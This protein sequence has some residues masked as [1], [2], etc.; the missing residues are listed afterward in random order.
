MDGGNVTPRGV[1]A[2]GFYPAMECKESRNVPTPIFAAFRVF[3]R[4]AAP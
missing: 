4:R 2:M 3:S 1:H